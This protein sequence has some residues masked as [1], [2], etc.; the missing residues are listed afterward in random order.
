MV[1]LIHGLIVFFVG[2]MVYQ[3][4]LEGRWLQQSIGGPLIEGMKTQYKGYDP[5]N[6]AILEQQNAGNIAYLKQRMDEVQGVSQQLQE[7]NGKVVA[8]Q[9]QVNGLMQSQQNYAAQMTGGSAPEISGVGEEEE[10]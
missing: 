9:E 6:V 7:V 5:N 1:G 8:L 2:L 3:I 4:L 10:E